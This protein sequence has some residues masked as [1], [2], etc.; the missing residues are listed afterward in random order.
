MSYSMA[1]HTIASR[2]DIKNDRPEIQQGADYSRFS[3][4]RNAVFALLKALHVA[5][6]VAGADLTWVYS[7]ICLYDILD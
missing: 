4:S 6:Y 3:I 7:C 5:L 2:Q 1:Q